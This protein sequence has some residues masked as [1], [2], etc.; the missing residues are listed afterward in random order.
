M[1]DIFSFII[2]SNKSGSSGGGQTSYVEVFPETKIKV[3]PF[4][5]I[6]GWSYGFFNDDGA[7]ATLLSLDKK[8]HLT[9]GDIDTEITFGIYPE[10]SD[11]FMAGNIDLGFGGDN[12]LDY[13]LEIGDEAK[14]TVL[15][16]NLEITEIAFKLEEIVAIAPSSQPQYAEVEYSSEEKIISNQKV[17]FVETDFPEGWSAGFLPFDE[18]FAEI[19]V[20]T[21]TKYTLKIGNNTYENLQFNT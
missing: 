5:M 9:L 4:D 6:E 13:Y 10:L 20:D 17:N 11:S 2:A 7:L 16:R 14:I 21:E 15:V 3:E 12:G 18:N 8:Y 19:S 1:F